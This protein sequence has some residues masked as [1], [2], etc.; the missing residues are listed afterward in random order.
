MIT[1]DKDVF[2]KYLGKNV[3]RETL[4]KFC[5]YHALLLKWQKKINLISNTT[6]DQIYT[7]H[8]L[9]SAQI[10]SFIN[11]KES[12]I[13]D[14]GSG[15]GFPGVVL[16]ILGFN[17]ITLIERDQKKAVFLRN[18]LRELNLDINVFEG[19]IINYSGK[20]DIVLSRALASL[21]SLLKLS[22]PVLKPDG[23][24]LFLKG[25][26]YNLEI[27]E[28]LKNWEMTFIKKN[29]I[30]SDNGMILKINNINPLL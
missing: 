6:L 1:N 8:F 26:S 30:T 27:K 23:F 10:S 17:N 12:S 4:N 19:D 24:A 25:K 28:A 16:A 11:N 7:R 20:L 21:D 22:Y 15:A 18:V 5:I 9:D 29:S 2:F 13:A 3:S 14:F